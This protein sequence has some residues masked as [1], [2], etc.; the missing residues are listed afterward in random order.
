M[1][2]KIKKTNF[3]DLVYLVALDI[4][5]MDYTSVDAVRVDDQL[6]G[7]LVTTEEGWGCEYIDITGNKI[8][9]GDADYDVAKYQLIKLISKF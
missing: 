7:F 4:D 6:V 2:V 9:F 5:K 1:N 3:A 8:D